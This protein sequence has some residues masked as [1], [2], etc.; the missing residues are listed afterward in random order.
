MNCMALE[1]RGD[2]LLVDCGVTFDNRHLG[3]DIVHPDFAALDSLGARVVGVV[4][5]HGHEDHIGALPYL[6]QRYD[7]PVWAPPYVLGLLRERTDEHE[8]LSHADLRATTPRAPFRAGSFDIEPVRVTHSIADATALAIRTDEGLIVH[9]GDFKF[10]ESPPDGQAID[11]ARFSELGDE[12]V[13]LLL[14]DSTNV[15]SE[16]PTGSEAGVGEVLDALVRGS[17]RAVVVAMFASNVHRLRLLGEIA[18]RNGRKIVLLGR[19]MGVHTRVARKTGYLPWPDDIVC[20]ESLCRDLPRERILAIAT[21]SQGEAR[22]AL[23]RLARGDHASFAL[24]P[25][26]AVFFSARA[27]PGNELAIQTLVGALLRRGVHVHTPSAVCGLHVSGHAHRPEQRAMIELVRPQH[28]VPVHGTLHHLTRHADLAGDSGVRSCLVIENG[29]SAVLSGD[30]LEKGAT[31]P[32][33]RI[34]RWAGRE[35][36]NGVLRERSILAEEGVAI[37]SV[38][39]DASGAIQDISVMTSGVTNDRHELERAEQAAR[40]EVAEQDISTS[41]E[42]LAERIRLVVRRAFR[43]ATGHKPV[44]L[45]RFRRHEER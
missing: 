27:I 10:D 18:R 41:D 35:V 31:F 22:A 25:G 24:E 16:G 29:Q 32:S 12:G 40:A 21:G 39:L 19:G 20:P 43:N 14:S 36:S 2:V 33:G 28:F 23:A 38:E 45:V 44:T 9:T 5:T 8:I 1:Q 13:S 37:V 15:D 4:V 11:S 17:E 3:V 6:L 30:G 34:Y 7:V 26:D 42:A